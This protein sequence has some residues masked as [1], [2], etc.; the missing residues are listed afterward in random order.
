MS[1]NGTPRRANQNTKSTSLLT[2]LL[3]D[4]TGDRLCPSHANKNGKRYR[5]YISKR[6]VHGA[7][8]QQGWRLPA[9]EIEAAVVGII[10]ILLNDGRRLLDELGDAPSAKVGHQK[11]IDAAERLAADLQ[12][13]DAAPKRDLVQELIERIE[14]GT[15]VIVVAI[16]RQSLVARLGVGTNASTGE[17][18]PLVIREA[19]QLCRRGIEA[20]LVL[21]DCVDRERHVDQSLCQLVAIARYWFE[22]LADGLVGS[23]QELAARDRVPESEI[24]RVL[25]LAF[26]APNIVEAVLDGRQP[27]EMTA[28]SLRRMEQFPSDWTAQRDALGI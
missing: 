5:Y 19:A 7:D 15:D 13:E 4:E 27:L 23:V 14:V 20:K 10:T 21:P 18:E 17:N 1:G 24:T 28:T 26:M 12:S 11:I 25:P 2:G 16:R 8:D 22:T 3:Y 6:L 9:R